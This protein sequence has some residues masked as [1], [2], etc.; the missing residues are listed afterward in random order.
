[1]IVNKK[2]T[3]EE[4]AKDLESIDFA[5]IEEADLLE[6]F[7]SGLKAADADCNCS[8]P[9]NTNCPCGGGTDS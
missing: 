1:V 8:C 6:V 2:K 4:V 7:G 3:P 9:P 5:E